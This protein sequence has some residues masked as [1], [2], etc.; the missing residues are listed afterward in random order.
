MLVP[1]TRIP[2]RPNWRHPNWVVGLAF[3][4]GLLIGAYLPTQERFGRWLEAASAW[5][6]DPESRP[7]QKQQLGPVKQRQLNR[8]RKAV[9]LIRA[10]RPADRALVP[11]VRPGISWHS[12]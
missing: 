9:A 4:V 8:L 3:A 10:L 5:L 12:V 7:V 11:A 2:I 6:S 1:K